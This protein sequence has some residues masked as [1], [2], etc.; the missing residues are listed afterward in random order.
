[1]SAVTPLD[2]DAAVRA[3]YSA[4]AHAREEE[5]CCP[6]SYDP[7]YLMVIPKEILERDYGCGDPTRHLRRGDRV[8][9]LG[10]GAGKACYI[11][12]QIVGPEGRV[13]GVDFNADMLALARQ[14]REKVGDAVGWHNVE[15]RRGRIEDVALDVE[16]LDGWLAAHPVQSA[17]CTVALDAEQRR[18]RAEAAMI[19][20][21]SV[22]VVVSNCVLNLVGDEK[23]PVLFR[24]IY[25][26]LA[27]GGRAVISDIVADEPV[28]SHLKDDPE[29]WSGCVSGAMSETG[30]LGAFEAAGFYG[31]EIV[32][33]GEKP[34]R[35]IE[36]IELR[37]VTVRA[38]RGKEGP[39]LE[40]NKGLIYRGPWKQVVDDDGH[41]FHR[42]VREAVCEKTFGIVSREPYVGAFEPVLPL[43]LK[44][45]S[46]WPEFDCRRKAPRH[47][48]E[49][50]GP[51]PRWT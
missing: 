18:L 39:C 1:M 10:S 44:P 16:A 38:F 34:W 2:T 12:S 36:E 48:K 21:Q 22:D 41:V 50:K 46:E 42:G 29:L 17:D 28:P 19:P 35:T 27:R 47:P 23:K 6:V 24:E 11:A 40:S 26:V 43:E 37:S 25:R 4:G 8:L 7:R 15:F 32:A 9:D 51:R 45:E 13:I 5:L 30:F 14:H 20:D 3:R 49:T 33:R 31:V